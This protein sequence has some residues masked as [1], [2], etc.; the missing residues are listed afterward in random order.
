MPTLLLLLAAFCWLAAGVAG[1]VGRRTEPLSLG[2]GSAGSLAGIV[3][4]C[5]ALA[6]PGRGLSFV[7]WNA[8]ATLEADALSAAFLLPLYVVA[9]LA[10]V[11]G[12]AY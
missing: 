6:S 4:A 3:G 10:W 11:Y 8:P 12:K 5:W 9:G 7:F 1:A 2:L